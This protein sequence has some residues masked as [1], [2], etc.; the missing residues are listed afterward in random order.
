VAFLFLAYQKH[1]AI[2]KK[3]PLHGVTRAGESCSRLEFP[4]PAMG[5]G[6][7]QAF[8]EFKIEKM[9]FGGNIAY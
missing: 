9:I 4:Y 5:M 8:Q 2:P 3:T 1:S 6:S 7:G